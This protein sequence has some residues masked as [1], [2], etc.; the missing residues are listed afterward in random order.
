MTF[1]WFLASVRSTMFYQVLVQGEALLTYFAFVRLEVDVTSV[2]TLQRAEN[3]E[4]F[5]TN[6]TRERG[7]LIRVQ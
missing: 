7:E 5:E 2:V 1:V 6:G 4:V 3:F